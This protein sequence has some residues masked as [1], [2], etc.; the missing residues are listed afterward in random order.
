MQYTFSLLIFLQVIKNVDVRGPASLT[1][2]A[3]LF[4]TAKLVFFS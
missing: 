1:M 3:L 4:C 2:Y